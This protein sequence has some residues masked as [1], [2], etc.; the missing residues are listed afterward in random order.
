MI[1]SSQKNENHVKSNQIFITKTVTKMKNESNNLV[2]RIANISSEIINSILLFLIKI[3]ANKELSELYL[4]CLLN[5]ISIVMACAFLWVHFSFFFWL[6]WAFIFVLS[7]TAAKLSIYNLPT[8]TREN[9]LAA[10]LF[11]AFMLFVE[12]VPTFLMLNSSFSTRDSEAKISFIAMSVVLCVLYAWRLF[13][14][15]SIAQKLVNPN[16]NLSKGF[17]SLQSKMLP[18][19]TQGNTTQYNATQSKK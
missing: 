19:L 4:S 2:K 12:L 11:I 13:L 18:Q 5:V 10:K 15:N 1:L 8:V 16:S 17:A 3:L 9:K 14:D 6:F 7:M